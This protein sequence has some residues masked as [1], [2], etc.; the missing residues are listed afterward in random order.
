MRPVAA[1]GFA[2]AGSGALLSADEALLAQLLENLLNN[3]VQHNPKPVNITVHTRRTGECFCLTVADDGIGY[4]SAVLTA[5]NAAEPAENAPHIF[6]L[7]VSAADRRRPWRQGSV[8]AEHPLWGK[9]N[10]LT[11]ISGSKYIVIE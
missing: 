9:N 8:R 6:G 7:Y 5:L 2:A 3:S 4:P 11:A 1:L 10:G